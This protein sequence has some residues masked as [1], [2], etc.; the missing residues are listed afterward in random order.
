MRNI[1]LELSYVE[2]QVLKSLVRFSIHQELPNK[3]SDEIINY[4]NIGQ[5]LI[6]K[7]EEATLEV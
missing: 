6:K 1:Q 7:I 3:L 2:A 4:V 5:T